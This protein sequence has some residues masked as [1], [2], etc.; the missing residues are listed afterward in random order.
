MTPNDVYMGIAGT[1][2]GAL[3]VGAGKLAWQAISNFFTGMRDDIR[4]IQENLSGIKDR[5]GGHDV[6]LGEIGT[7]LESH[8]KQDDER[9]DR[10]NAR[11]HDLEEA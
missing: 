4:G 10:I 2:G 8:E 9:H 3:L 5:V 6:R 11:L 1:A 7:F